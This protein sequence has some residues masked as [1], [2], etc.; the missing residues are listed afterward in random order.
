[1]WQVINGFHNPLTEGERTLAKFLDDT[2]PQPWKIYV[3]PYLNGSF[4][5]IIVFNP[6]IGAVIYEV[7]DWNL[8]N[9]HRKKDM[10]FVK[11]SRGSYPVDDPRKQVNHY[12]T[13]LLE[14][15][16]PEITEKIWSYGS[17]YDPIKTYVYFHNER[18]APARKLFP[19]GYT[20]IIGR[21]DL[22]ESNVTT[23]LPSFP[24]TVL[25]KEIKDEITWWL[26]P[27][28][29]SVERTR[30]LN[31]TP[32]Q[33]QH[34]EPKSGHARL[35]GAVGSGKTLVV[36][37]RAANLASQTRRVLILTF[38]I[39]LWHYIRDMIRQAPYE[40]EWKNIVLTH[41]HGFCNDILKELGVPAPHESYLKEIVPTIHT[42]LDR[43]IERGENI[44]R[45]KY[46]AILI[47]EGQDYEW[48]WYNC[49]CRFLTEHDE[50]LLVCDEK[51]N[52]Y[53]KETSWIDGKMRNVKFRGRWGELKTV[54]RLPKLIGDAVNAFSKTF[55]LD[56]TIEVEDYVQSTLLDFDR[57]IVPHFVWKNIKSENWR[58]D[59]WQAYERIKLKCSQAS[60]GHASDIVILIIDKGYGME[61]VNYFKQR[62]IGVDHVFEDKQERSYHRRKK[63][64]WPGSGRLKMCT[65]HSFKGWEAR[66]VILFIP[67]DL[68]VFGKNK[69]A[70][71]YTAMTR[72]RE[73]L[74]VL[75][76]NSRYKKFGESLPKD[77]DS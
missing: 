69:D 60:E 45:L 52:I 72:A 14:Q 2:L 49:L 29:H 48:E 43:A 70:V 30:R 1:M 23:I 64:F 9:Y 68:A 59:I 31:L 20:K 50:L 36:A 32:K 25:S 67:N 65:I 5:D 39:T 38:N 55:D 33:K 58:E 4:P 63:S 42:A 54:Y 26:E 35:R 53:G 66:H 28:T 37:E 40:F 18:G 17:S 22:K 71:I 12:K 57:P 74:I 19:R 15:L 76:S 27:P 77:W 11:D 7:K 61:A 3:Q 8:N 46:D 21:D 62:N 41:F 56:Q 6:A 51:Q 10:L 13:K 47:D 16:P 24:H 34:A 44:E 73:N 75:N